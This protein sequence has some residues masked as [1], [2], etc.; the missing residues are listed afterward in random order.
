MPNRKTRHLKNNF[1]SLPLGGMWLIPRG[2]KRMSLPV[3]QPDSA[4]RVPL[5]RE[6]DEERMRYTLSPGQ[7]NKRLWRHR[8]SQLLYRL[9]VAFFTI[10]SLFRASPSAQRIED[11][12]V[13]AVRFLPTLVSACGPPESVVSVEHAAT[14]NPP[15]RSVAKRDPHP[16]GLSNTPVA[17]TTLSTAHEATP[18]FAAANRGS[19]NSRVPLP[20][21]NTHRQQYPTPP[22]YAFAKQ[23]LFSVPQ[24]LREKVMTHSVTSAKGRVVSEGQTS[25]ERAAFRRLATE[26][27]LVKDHALSNAGR[28]LTPLRTLFETE[29]GTGTHGRLPPQSVVVLDRAGGS[30]LDIL[31]SLIDEAD[32]A[33]IAPESVI[34]K[35]P[36]HTET[37]FERAGGQLGSSTLFDRIITR[38]AP[39]HAIPD[40]AAL[41]VDLRTYA[42]S[43]CGTQNLN[44]DFKQPDSPKEDLQEGSKKK[45]EFTVMDFDESQ[46]SRDGSRPPERHTL[47]EPVLQ[48]ISVDW[49]AFSQRQRPEGLPAVAGV[50]AV[51]LA[52]DSQQV[53]INGRT[54]SVDNAE[55]SSSDDGKSGRGNSIFPCDP[56]NN[57]CRN[58]FVPLEAESLSKGSKVEANGVEF[59][60]PNPTVALTQRGD[61]SR[62]GG[63]SPEVS[64]F[65]SSVASKFASAARAAEQASQAA[66]IREGNPYHPQDESHRAAN[67]GASRNAG[68]LEGADMEMKAP[69][70]HGGIALMRCVRR[71]KNELHG[72]VVNTDMK[73]ASGTESWSISPS[74]ASGEE[75]HGSDLVEKDLF[76]LVPIRLVPAVPGCKSQVQRKCR[77]EVVKDSEPNATVPI[78]EGGLRPERV[79]K[80]L[81]LCDVNLASSK[82]LEPSPC[83]AISPP[84]QAVLRWAAPEAKRWAEGMLLAH[85]KRF[86]ARPSVQSTTTFSHSSHYGESQTQ[87]EDGERDVAIPVW[88]L[89]IPVDHILDVPD[90][91]A[92]PGCVREQDSAQKRKHSRLPGRA[93]SSC[94]ITSAFWH[95]SVQKLMTVQL[96]LDGLRQQCTLHASSC[97]EKQSKTQTSS[98]IA[99]ETGQYKYPSN[100]ARVGDG[101]KTLAFA[102][103]NGSG[104]SQRAERRVSGVPEATLSLLW[105][106]PSNRETRKRLPPEKQDSEENR[107]NRESALYII[108]QPS[109]NVD[110]DDEEQLWVKCST[111]LPVVSQKKSLNGP[112]QTSACH[113]H[114]IP[115]FLKVNVSE[116]RTT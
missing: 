102:E 106:S 76:R 62:G 20:E 100:G 69:E 105:T 57:E 7:K 63:L 112:L 93:L 94:G 99:A 51:A 107:G 6:H 97:W 10:F 85:G 14:D 49:Q 89:E 19:P 58:S 50:E 17:L 3:F 109:S 103:M 90:Q 101:D 61:H 40:N 16:D 13:I 23:W 52:S 110:M 74:K 87:T 91:E 31:V 84:R 46:Q 25:W 33:Y 4:V 5:I 83:T 27:L 60:P 32:G 65:L 24:F 111:H 8:E 64:H 71:R 38:I 113:T 18:P 47:T 72:S 66:V 55:P 2:S 95:P 81:N 77:E 1:G 44:A 116:N 67:S 35:S 88:V 98:T 22:I 26:R 70:K 96:H 48:I 73:A 86:N 41:Y 68:I 78:S 115:V 28:Y 11:V 43:A 29:N 34:G 79:Q 21:Q 30:P 80:S 36:T 45:T 75:A 59:L 108:G 53:T 82:P 39:L 15:F 114:P 56:S 54:S 92:A 9:L 37:T 42:A 104:F 12:F